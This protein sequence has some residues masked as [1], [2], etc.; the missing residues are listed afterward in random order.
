MIEPATTRTPWFSVDASRILHGDDLEIALD[1]A[2]AFGID[3]EQLQS[4]NG[5]AQVAE[6][7]EPLR[8]FLEDYLSPELAGE[9]DRH[10]VV[11]AY[12]RVGHVD[13]TGPVIDVV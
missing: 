7:C 9:G 2:D 4:L 13:E 11:L 12:L 5:I 1:R 10:E 6:D 3:M 8:R